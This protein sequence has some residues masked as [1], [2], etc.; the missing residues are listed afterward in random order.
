VGARGPVPKRSTQRRRMNKPKT[1]V[2]KAKGATRIPIPRADPKWHPAARRFYAALNESGQAAF[3]EPSDW[4]LAWL[5]A[6]SISRDLKPQ[7]IG[8]NEQ[9]GKPVFAVVPLKGASLQAYLKAFS[10][11]LLTE[12]DRRRAGLELERQADDGGAGE[13]VPSL[14]DYRQRFAG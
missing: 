5:T 1:P 3:Y 9:T 6:E 10:A 2:T 7:V 12:G 11:L 4:Q 14:D 8:V 13:D